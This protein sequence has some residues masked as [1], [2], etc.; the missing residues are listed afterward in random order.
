MMVEAGAVAE[1]SAASMIEKGRLIPR[2]KKVAIKTKTE[3][4]TASRTVMITTRIPFF[5]SVSMRK[6]SPVE[7][8]MK[9]SAMS[10]RKSIPVM[11]LSGTT[12]RQ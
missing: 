9:A 7:K 1:A 10:D 2:K 8:A 3:A 4:R 5:L 11:T 6:N 12:W